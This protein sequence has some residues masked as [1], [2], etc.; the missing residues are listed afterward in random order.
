M[1]KYLVILLTGM[2]CCIGITNLAA[3]KSTKPAMKNVLVDT[4]LVTAVV[5]TLE[6]GQKTDEHTHPAHYFYALTDCKLHVK[7]SDGETQDWDVKSGDSGY[8]DAE[9]PHVTQNNGKST[10]KFLLVELKEHPYMYPNKKMK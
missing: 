1:R 9:R 4:A 6:P 8:Q 2:I 5:V 10:A 3:Q 7:Y